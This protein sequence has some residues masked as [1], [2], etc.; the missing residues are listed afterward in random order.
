[1]P[2]DCVDL[3]LREMLHTYSQRIMQCLVELHRRQTCRPTINMENEPENLK[4][5][6]ES[7]ILTSHFINLLQA[8]AC[9]KFDEQCRGPRVEMTMQLL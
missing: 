5:K 8:Y 1:L 7:L 2:A 9:M 3:M 6:L 4:Q